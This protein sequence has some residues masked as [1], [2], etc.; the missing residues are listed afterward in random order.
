M[1]SITSIIARSGAL[2]KTFPL[3]KIIYFKSLT[4]YN[5]RPMPP[6]DMNVDNRAPEFDQFADGYSG[7]MED[8]LKRLAGEGFVSFIEAKVR[9]LLKYLEKGLPA[10]ETGFEKIK[11]LDFGCGTGDFLMVLRDTGFAGRLEGCDVS[12]KMLDEAGRRCQG[13]DLPQFHLI[14]EDCA[15]P[16]A[17]STFDI[18]VA[19]CVFHHIEPL[20]HGRVFT[21]IQR[22]LKPGG[23]IVFFEHNPL[24]PLTRFIV[25]RAPIDRNAILIRASEAKRG[26]TSAGFCNTIVNYIMFFPPRFKARLFEYAESFMKHIPLGGQYVIVG[27]KARA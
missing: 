10:R 19:C 13:G 26:M 22:I 20:E 2:Y 23:R 21:E 25:K 9:W 7:G 8:P 5:H 24:N 3:T 18:I 16:F 14:R 27:E 1:Y 11:L 6:E 4:S 15:T 17:E 12:R